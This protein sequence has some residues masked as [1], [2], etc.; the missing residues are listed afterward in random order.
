MVYLVIFVNSQTRDKPS[1]LPAGQLFREDPEAF[2]GQSRD[3]VPPVCPGSSLA[4]S[5]WDNAGTPHRGGFVQE[6]SGTDARANSS[7]PLFHVESSGSTRE[8]PH[9]AS[10]WDTGHQVTSQTKVRLK[11]PIDDKISI[12][13]YARPGSVSPGPPPWSQAWVGAQQ[14]QRPVAESLLQGTRRAQRKGNVEPASHSVRRRREDPKQVRRVYV[15]RLVCGTL[16]NFPQTE[17][18]GKC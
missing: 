7:W 15:S 16:R 17:L 11:K 1:D 10:Q 6:A 4:S 2:P 9:G 12:A 8:F 13:R 3:I 14:A 18:E 5:Q